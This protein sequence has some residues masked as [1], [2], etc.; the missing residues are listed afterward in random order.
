MQASRHEAVRS[1][2]VKF[3]FDVDLIITLDRLKL[4]KVLKSLSSIGG[5]KGTSANLILTP[6]I[7]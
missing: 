4:D 2:L 7:E 5:I 3:N 6:L 1:L